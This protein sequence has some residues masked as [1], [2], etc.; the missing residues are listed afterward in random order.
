MVVVT[1]EEV[2]VIGISEEENV[3]LMLRYTSIAYRILFSV[4]LL[5][6]LSKEAFQN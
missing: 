4:L 5:L 2:P 3:N 1:E 6:H